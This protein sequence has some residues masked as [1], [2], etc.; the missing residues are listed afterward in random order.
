MYACR[1]TRAFGVDPGL[2]ILRLLTL[3]LANG[4]K[5]QRAMSERV[6]S[7][8]RPGF[9]RCDILRE[10]RF[11]RSG[12]GIQRRAPLVVSEEHV[13]ANRPPAVFTGPHN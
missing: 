5:K 8:G 11:C 13:S 10:S 1:I 6:G 3:P 12:A 2:R 9:A 7:E 4:E